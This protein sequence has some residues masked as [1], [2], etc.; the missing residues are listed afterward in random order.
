MH[1][2]YAEAGGV[3]PGAPREAWP[4]LARA[5]EA[6]LLGADPSLV[7]HACAS[8]LAMRQM[9]LCRTNLGWL[10]ARI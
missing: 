9:H 7:R 1:L 10:A 2:A 3:D 5:F 4:A 6:F 8:G